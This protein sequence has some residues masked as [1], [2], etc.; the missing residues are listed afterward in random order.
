MRQFLAGLALAVALATPSHSYFE[1]G[2]ERMPF[3]VQMLQGY[4]MSDG[5]RMAAI[6]IS[7][8]PG[9]YTYW[10]IPG[11]AG[12]PTQLSWSPKG[13]N[14]KGLTPI[15]P[16]PKII[17]SYGVPS[18]GYKG[19]VILPLLITP[20]DPEKAMKLA[21]TL[22]F[23]VCKEVCIPA[24]ERI[25]MV[26]HPAGEQAESLIKAAV[27]ETEGFRN[28]KGVKATCDI[29]LDS[30]EIVVAAE[31]TGGNLS[32]HSQFAVFELADGASD[33]WFPLARPATSNGAVLA[34]SAGQMF[35]GNPVAG[36]DRGLLRITL[37]GSKGMVELSGCPAP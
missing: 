25:D 12:I 32:G 6:Q 4:K 36:I 7:L 24:S 16:H 1:Y 37:L 29:A 17:D 33:I 34:K 15:W 21:G 10:R 11:E 14:L 2:S 8:S 27:R 5:S 22:D 28:P 13:S 9:W 26:F 31:I 23:G 18:F 19:R 3:E 20:H 35:G 30:G